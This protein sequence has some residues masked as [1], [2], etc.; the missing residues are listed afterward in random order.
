MK[1]LTS[2]LAL[3]LA[4][5][6]MSCGSKKQSEE[7]ESIVL[8]PAEIEISGDLEGCF[9]VIDREYKVVGD[10]QSIITVELIREENLLPY[11]EDLS[12]QS[13]STIMSS[14]H[15]QVGFGIEFLDDDGNILDKVSADGSGF[16]GSYDSDEAVALVKLKAG[17]KGSIRFIVTDEAKNA[18]SFR[19]TSAYKENGSSRDSSSSYSSENS[20]DND[21]GEFGPMPHDFDSEDNISGTSSV[22]NANIDEWLKS[23][24]KYTDRYISFMKKAKNGDM[25]AMSEYGKLLEEA[26]DYMSKLERVKGDLT[27]AQLNKFNQIN[28]KKLEALQKMK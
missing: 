17:K 12:P 10:I 11:D 7:S 18:T 3:M 26:N 16:S 23:Y 21:Y 28:I 22:G 20:S 6:L 5:I 27:P 14:P 8:K 1:K 24:E 25:S 19:I 9:K 15:V 13:F 2:L 4:I